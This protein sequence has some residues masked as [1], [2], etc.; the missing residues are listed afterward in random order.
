MAYSTDDVGARWSA[1]PL[2][3]SLL[4]NGRAICYGG[5]P[6]KFIAVGLQG[7]NY[8]QQSADGITWT[9]V[10]T[11]E[12]FDG[13]HGICY[14]GPAGQKKFIV[15]GASGKMASSVD[16]NTWTKIETDIFDGLTIYCV[17][18]GDGVYVAA[19]SNGD[20][21]GA[22]TTTAKLAYSDDGITWVEADIDSLS[23]PNTDIKKIAY[24]GGKFIGVGGSAG[25]PGIPRMIA[26]VDGITWMDIPAADL[27]IT[28][29]FIKDI[30]YG[31]G[32]F[33]AVTAS[34]QILYS[35][36]QE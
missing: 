21:D 18:Y 36:R 30:A 13:I 17:S 14:D 27:N 26:S 5:S 1:I 3:N 8:M 6:G 35:N 7:T 29:T 10:S 25:T 11:A 9:G 23:D 4:G 19:G 34:G 28:T 22:G 12:L 16:G 2:A 33:T 32:M 24:G 31:G 20:V 15:V